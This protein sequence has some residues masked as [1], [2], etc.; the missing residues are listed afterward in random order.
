VE[1]MIQ[2]CF[3]KPPAKESEL[4]RHAMPGDSRQIGP[5]SAT[6]KDAVEQ[7]REQWDTGEMGD[8]F[9]GDMSTLLH[10]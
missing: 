5:A 3:Q 8:L 10:F 1:E 9:G 4:L 6:T 7:T 2:Q